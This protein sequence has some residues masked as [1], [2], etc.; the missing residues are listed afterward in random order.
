M[1]G[2]ICTQRQLIDRVL[3]F[4]GP[5]L[6][7]S[8][9]RWVGEHQCLWSVWFIPKWHGLENEVTVFDKWLR[10]KQ[11][12][13]DRFK[14][15]SR[16]YASC[17]LSAVRKDWQPHPAVRK[18]AWR[19][20]AEWRKCHQLNVVFGWQWYLFYLPFFMSVATILQEVL[21]SLTK[22]PWDIIGWISIYSWFFSSF[23]AAWTAVSATV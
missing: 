21:T 22:P 6:S 20:A 16:N 23:S 11:G 9:T 13:D 15:K 12:K 2:W 4:S 1:H 8:V 14:T 17:S 7:L 19:T 3:S 5:L 18:V 10:T